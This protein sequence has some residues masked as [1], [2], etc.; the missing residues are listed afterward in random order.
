MSETGRTFVEV[1]LDGDALLSDIDEYVDRWHEGNCAGPLWQFLGF[2]ENEYAVWV[3]RP[4]TLRYILFAHRHNTRLQEALKWSK[5]QPI[6]ARA[7]S[8]GE[9]EKI[10]QWL[11]ESGRLT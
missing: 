8:P 1:C 10:M 4:E 3:E 11:K 2:T 7:G 5:G 6:A 9:A